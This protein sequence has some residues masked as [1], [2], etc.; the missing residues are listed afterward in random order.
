MY[1]KLKLEKYLIICYILLLSIYY[2][3]ITNDILILLIGVSNI[4]N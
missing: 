2:I 3:M 4:N 1:K